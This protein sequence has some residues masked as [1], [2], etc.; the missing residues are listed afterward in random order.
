MKDAALHSRIVA[1][2]ETINDD[3]TSRGRCIEIS[4]LKPLTERPD[5]E[6][7]YLG[8]H[9]SSE[10]KRVALHGSNN[11]VSGPRNVDRDLVGNCSDNGFGVIAG[12]IRAGEKKTGEKQVL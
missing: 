5:N 4:L 10:D 2:I 1:F 11:F 6:G 12:G 8:F 7:N 9:G 3:K